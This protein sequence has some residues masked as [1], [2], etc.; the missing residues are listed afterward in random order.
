MAAVSTVAK[1]SDDAIRQRVI[2]QLGWEPVLA[3]SDIGVAVKDGVVTLTGTVTSLWA[4]LEAEKAAKRVHGVRAVANDIQLNL[5]SKRTD[6]E[7][8]RDAVQEIQAHV[9]IPG[10]KIK[11]TVRDGWVTLEGEVRWQ[12]QRKLAESA[13]RRL[14]GV[15]GIENQI[16]IKTNLKP[17]KVK[18]QIEAALR[19]SAETDARR[20]AV[21]AEGGKVTLRGTVR[22]WSERADAE[23]AA[24]S[25]PGVTEVEDLIEVA[26]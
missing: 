4:K 22:S 10:E 19:R 9:L 24:W 17:T 1:R 25:A 16:V 20:I 26:A 23:R 13:V 14:D 7:I 8:A 18:E 3:N 11:V 2:S 6:P 21:E 15:A 5:T 12:F